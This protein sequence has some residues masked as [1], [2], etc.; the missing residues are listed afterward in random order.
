[1][2]NACVPFRCALLLTALLTACGAR[3]D[4]AQEPRP[5]LTVTVAQPVMET[6][7]IRLSANGNIEAWQEAAVSADVQSLRLLEVRVDVGDTVSAGQVLA[8]FD[9]EPVKIEVAQARAALAQTR[10]AMQ[11]ARENAGRARDL[12]GSGALSEQ[13]V[14]QY[15][16]S[17]QTA[18]A[19]VAVAEAALAA[20][21][22]RLART[23]V[24]APD[25]GVISARN[26]TVGAVFGPGSE[27]FRLIRKGR[28]EWRAELM[29]NELERVAPGM[30]ARL[31]LADG[32][33]ITGVLRMLAPTVDA[34]TR[35]GL[36]YVDLPAE[37]ALRPGMFVRGEFDLGDSP[38]LT[39]PLQAVSMR[40]AF[41]HVFSLE[42]DGVVRQVKVAM[43]RRNGE[44]VEIVAG[45]APQ[46]RI[47]V[48]GAGF[49]NDG[50]RVRVADA[51]EV[52]A[53]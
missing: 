51:P 37:A 18:Q 31:T 13:L 46:A 17:E 40:E 5:A 50:D 14:T 12:R 47:V 34:R 38:A 39:V 48:R 30:S 29:D 45:L 36:A 23:R 32:R 16:S 21:E 41:S 3:Q 19:Q 11:V 4:G 22:L 15:L 7:P 49:L 44:R 9:D 25:D 6:W 43:G 2:P 42:T 28:L 8:V 24:L 1:M 26:A 52:E 35:T 27:L 33:V 10:A 53:R 20:Q